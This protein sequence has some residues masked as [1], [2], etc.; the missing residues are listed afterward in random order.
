M[1]KIFICLILVLAGYLF[2]QKWSNEEFISTKETMKLIK[3][4]NTNTPL[5]LKAKIWG[6]SGNHE[7]IILSQSD[8]NLSNKNK[9]YIF[10]VSEVFYK[11]EK[12]NNVILYAPESAISE[13]IIKMSNVTIKGMKKA[14]EIRDFSLNYKKYGLKRISVYE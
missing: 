9:D 7:E 6:V 14:D 11:V 10:F 2:Y 13:P 12:D 5:F 4:G 3:L 8:S 1:V